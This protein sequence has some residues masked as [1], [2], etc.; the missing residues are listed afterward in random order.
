[1]KTHPAVPLNEQTKPA[2]LRI[3]RARRKLRKSADID[4]RIALRNVIGQ[5][6]AE[7]WRLSKK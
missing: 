6:T 2:Y 1:M 4:E 5:A 7:L 3:Q